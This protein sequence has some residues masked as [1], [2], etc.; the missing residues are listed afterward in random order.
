MDALPSDEQKA[1]M[2]ADWINLVIRKDGVAEARRVWDW[3]SEKRGKQ[4]AA[5]AGAVK[6]K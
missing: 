6:P 4:L 1:K 5:A 3:W 2:L